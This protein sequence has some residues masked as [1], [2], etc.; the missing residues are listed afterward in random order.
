M[1]YQ[2][3]PVNIVNKRKGRVKTWLIVIEVLIALSFVP[4]LAVAGLSVMAFDSGYSVAA[5]VFVGAMW[6][7][8]L[9]A[10]IFSALAWVFYAKKKY[11]LAALCPLLSF[12]PAAVILIMFALDIALSGI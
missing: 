9:V 4:W 6:S 1:T 5:V 7:Y 3:Q 10:I 8:P 12:L 11:K 2:E